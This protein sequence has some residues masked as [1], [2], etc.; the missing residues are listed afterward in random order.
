MSVVER[1]IIIELHSH[2]S[3]S[4]M[5]HQLFES[6]RFSGQDLYIEINL[7]LEEISLNLTRK[8]PQLTQIT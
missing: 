6:K 8:P 4:L 7:G 1:R 3:A 5:Y 2:F